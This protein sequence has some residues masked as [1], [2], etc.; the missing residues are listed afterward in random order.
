M[1]AKNEKP[2]AYFAA[3]G[4]S[5]L[6]NYPLWKASAIGQAGFKLK[7]K[8]YLG[9][10]AEAL[11][12]PYRA[13]A[14]VVA[15]MTWARAAIFYGSDYGRIYLKAVGA[16]SSVATV[17]PPL[18]LSIMVQAVNMPL[19][20]CSIMLQDPESKFKSVTAVGR[21]IVARRGYQG[22]W[23]GL[24]AGIAKTVPK[25]VTAVVVKQQLD[26]YLAPV[27]RHSDR[28]GWLLR[29]AKKAVVAG[30]AGAVLTNPF[31]VI[32]NTMFKTELTMYGA[33][34]HLYQAEGMAFAARG[35]AKNLVAVAIPVTV[36]IFLT[37]VYSNWL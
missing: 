19:V 3:S 8:T 9:Q 28:Q 24:S 25:Y 14:H 1:S 10:Y 12:P 21:D 15:G 5:A 36:T 7:S 31:D 26:R 34:Q 6:I 23:H 22:L 2:L 37:D 17:T 20:R 27:D 33:V 11:R 30:V 18:L 35:V 13:A 29:S 4:T 32:R 16:P